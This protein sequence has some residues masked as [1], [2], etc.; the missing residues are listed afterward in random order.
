M[1]NFKLKKTAWRKDLIVD[2]SYIKNFT[3]AHLNWEINKIERKPALHPIAGIR[4]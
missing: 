4:K 2:S 3:L 1:I